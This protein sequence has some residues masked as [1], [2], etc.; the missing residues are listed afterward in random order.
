MADA[1]TGGSS[2]LKE[3]IREFYAERARKVSDQSKAARCCSSV[4]SCCGPT[5]VVPD[6]ESPVWAAATPPRW[7]TCTLAR[8]C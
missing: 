4:S 5:E 8:S 2:D 6:D 1:V 7:P 3:E